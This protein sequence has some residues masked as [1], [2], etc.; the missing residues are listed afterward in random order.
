MHRRHP[1]YDGSAGPR[2][3]SFYFRVDLQETG[4]K[5]LEFSVHSTLGD[6]KG[7]S[8]REFRE[9]QIVMH[10][11]VSSMAPFDTYRITQHYAYEEGTLRETV[12][13]LDH[14]GSKEKDWVR[15]HE[16]ATLF[17]PTSPIPELKR[18]RSTK[19]NMRP[20]I[21]MRN[22]RRGGRSRRPRSMRV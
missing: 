7:N 15:N 19:T 18:S 16:V 21:R 9:A 8:D 13:L 14:D 2:D 5:G 1:D 3:Q 11:N 12:E 17:A 22:A 6:G 10:A 4:E 20:H